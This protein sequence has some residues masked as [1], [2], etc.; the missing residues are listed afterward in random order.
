MGEAIGFNGHREPWPSALA[1]ADAG[2]GRPSLG[3]ARVA[4]G[5]HALGFHQEVQDFLGR[6]PRFDIVGAAADADRLVGIIGSRSPDVIVACPTVAREL[7]HPSLGERRPPLVIVVEEMT[8]PVLREAIDLGA[9]FVFAWPEERAELAR[10]VA[11]L[12]GRRADPGGDR[13]K[14]VAVQGA[15][16]GAGA[17]FVA[18]H[19]TAALSAEGSAAVLVDAAVTL[20]DASAALGVEPDAQPRTVLDLIPVMNELSPGHV[21]DAL[22]HH[23]RGFSVL[24]APP[25]PGTT[26][27]EV[28][29]PLMHAAIECLAE[30]NEWVVVLLPRATDPTA[31]AAARGADQFVVVTPLDLFSLYGAKRTMESLREE[32][33]PD[34]WRVVINRPTRPSLGT[35][36]VQRVLGMTPVATI[37]SDGR[38]RRFQ[39]RGELLR[40]WRS[41][42]GRDIR[43]VARRLA[44]DG[45]ASGTAAR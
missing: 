3:S 45:A 24:L 6:D 2:E 33:N 40:R 34:V 31:R 9:E 10:T 18:T 42:A 11:G 35:K 16:G 36:D 5:I 4:V 43:R 20:S 1:V 27:G 19:L 21:Q 37:R 25:E 41:G 8:V 39:E 22:F 23:P 28:P 7:R 13:G 12:G 15:R 14:V 29:P 38:I 30:H 44:G 26:A 17:T 32:V